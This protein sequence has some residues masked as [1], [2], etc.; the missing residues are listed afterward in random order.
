[1]RYI[2][3]VA[4]REPQS[5]I[6]YFATK[7]LVDIDASVKADKVD[8][9]LREF[10]K[11]FVGQNHVFITQSSEKHVQFSCKNPLCYMLHILMIC[12]NLVAW[13]FDYIVD[14]V[15]T[16]HWGFAHEMRDFN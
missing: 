9:F 16:R 8:L 11:V 12:R 2:P 4:D 15:E 10:R 6:L 1:M 7:L 3:Q 5:E 13:E 14:S